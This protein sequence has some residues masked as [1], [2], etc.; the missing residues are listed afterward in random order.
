MVLKSKEPMSLPLFFTSFFEKKNN[1]F[2]G[3]RGNGVG[4][5]KVGNRTLTN[6]VK[7]QVATQLN[8]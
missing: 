4:D 5:Y 1:K 2:G 6:K 8:Y 7:I 3:R